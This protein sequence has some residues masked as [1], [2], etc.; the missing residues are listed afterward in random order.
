MGP[1]CISIVYDINRLNGGLAGAPP[2]GICGLN[3][4]NIRLFPLQ[5]RVRTLFAAACVLSEKWYSSA[6]SVFA[7]YR[8][9][10][11]HAQNRLIGS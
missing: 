6:V 3:P 8:S 5:Q 4:D 1:F 2:Q 11:R 7:F 9:L 10:E